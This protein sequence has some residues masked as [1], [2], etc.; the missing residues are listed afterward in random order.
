MKPINDIYIHIYIYTLI[1]VS[2]FFM[3][4]C[5]H[6]HYMYSEYT[7]TIYTYICKAFVHAHMEFIMLYI[8]HALYHNVISILQLR[9]WRLKLRCVY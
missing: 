4:I 2:M 1:N 6:I 3:C 5:T 8:L 7:H 9:N